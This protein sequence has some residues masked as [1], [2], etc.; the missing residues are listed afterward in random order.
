M[1]RT[2]IE[3]KLKVV[4]SDLFDESIEN[5]NAATSPDTLEK[6]DSLA[7][8]KLINAL[9]ECFE[10]VVPPEDQAEILTF[11]LAADVGGDLRKQS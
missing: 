11:E 1:E 8:I 3:E 10:I 4:F 7:H 5:I 2:E 9:E 6:W